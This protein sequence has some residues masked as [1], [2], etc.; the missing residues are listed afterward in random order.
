VTRDWPA[1]ACGRPLVIEPLG[2]RAAVRKDG[3]H[4]TAAQEFVRFLVAEGWLAS[5]LN[6]SDQRTR[7]SCYRHKVA[8]GWAAGCGVAPE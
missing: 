2:D 8:A 1:G 3:K 5:S 7:L 4:V 6:F